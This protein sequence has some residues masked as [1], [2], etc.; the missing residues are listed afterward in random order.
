[1][2]SDRMASV[3]TLAAGV[4]HEINNP[5]ASVLANLDFVLKGVGTARRQRR[6]S[7]PPRARRGAARRPR[8]REPGAPRSSATCASSRAPRP[9]GARRSTSPASSSRRSAWP[10]TRSGTARSSS[11]ITARFRSSTPTK[12][13]LG[14]VF[15]NLVVN[16]AQ[17]IPEGHADENEIRVAHDAR[18]RRGASSSRSRDTGRRH[19][20]GG[21]WRA[22]SRRSSRP[23]RWASA[24]V[25]G[26]RSASGSSPGSA[27]RSTVDSTVGVGT[28][29][30]VTLPPARGGRARGGAG[31]GG[32][33]GVAPRPHPDRRRRAAPSASRSGACSPATTKS[34][35]VTER[36]GGA[37]AHR[38]RRAVRRHPVRS[39]DAGD[40]RA[41][42]STQRS[43]RPRPIR[44]RASCS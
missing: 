6:R 19:P 34:S 31:G 23:S 41:S 38:R 21:A 11:R 14:Q 12:P 26:C 16:A 15:L 5:L 10:G 17:A 9:T 18:R 7:R 25:W 40:E 36:R 13:R 22:C 37:R 8:R 24:P 27:A 42:I 28:T 2:I 43:R 30:R 4:A 20:A 29:F 1:M 33:A 32:P 39:D 35:S 3:G 44:R